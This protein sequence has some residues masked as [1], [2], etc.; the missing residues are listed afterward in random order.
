[1][2]TSVSSLARVLSS[3]ACCILCVQA[4]FTIIYALELGARVYTKGFLMSL[5]ISKTR[6][7]FFMV[8]ISV[9]SQ[10]GLVWGWATWGLGGSFVPVGS[11]L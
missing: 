10:V 4:V 1:M 5:K 9:I 3:L 8:L 2:P 7:D 6:T 11:S